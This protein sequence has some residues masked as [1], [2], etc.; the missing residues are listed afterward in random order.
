MVVASSPTRSSSR[1]IFMPQVIWRSSNSPRCL[2]Q[3]VER[4]AVYQDFKLV[5]GLIGLKR[6]PGEGFIAVEMGTH[7]AS[8]HTLGVTRHDDELF[9]EL[10]KGLLIERD[11]RAATALSRCIVIG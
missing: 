11:A 8:D 4:H 7:R 6:L 5:D 10:R 2:C 9:F 3:Q 1:A